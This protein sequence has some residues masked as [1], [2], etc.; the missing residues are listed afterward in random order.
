MEQT[1][2]ITS[3]A[4]MA[5]AWAVEFAPRLLAAVI[6]FAVGTVAAGWVSGTMDMVIKRTNA[7][8]ATVRPF[9]VHVVRYSIMVLVFI[10][11]LG[12]L[13]FQTTS[14][15]AVVGAAGLAIGLALQGTLSNIAAGLMLLW[16]RPFEVGDYVEANNMSGTI[17]STGLFAC[18]LRTY[19]GVRLFAP[20]ST[21]W[22]VPLRNLSRTEGRMVALTVKLGANSDTNA[23]RHTI[24]ETLK[25]DTRVE[26]NPAPSTFLES[27]DVGGSLVG[28]RFWTKAINFGLVQRSILDALRDKLDTNADDNGRNIQQIQRL[29]PGANDMTRLVDFSQVPIRR[30]D[31]I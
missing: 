7:I 29:A 22:N 14:L 27:Y 1:A 16:L 23:A 24:E 6:I 10:L 17:E 25:G 12:Q 18:V 21:L 3:F 28:V 9:L 8:D 13:G 31:N 20:N 19:D 4:G 5:W 11:T 26:A 30:R 2:E 15:L